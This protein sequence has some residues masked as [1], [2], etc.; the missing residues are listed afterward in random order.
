MKLGKNVNACLEGHHENPKQRSLTQRSTLQA[1]PTRRKKKGTPIPHT[2]VLTLTSALVK[3][4]H[5]TTRQAA[6]RI[7][8]P[9]LPRYKRAFSR[10]GT[11]PI[12]PFIIS[13]GRR[14]AILPRQRLRQKITTVGEHAQVYLRANTAQNAHTNERQRFRRNMGGIPL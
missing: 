4:R 13:V 2:C 5:S 8:S 9:P 14:Y 6:C 10:A 7:N 1:R 11:I 3:A 12:S